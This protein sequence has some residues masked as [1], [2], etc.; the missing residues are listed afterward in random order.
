MEISVTALNDRSSVCSAVQEARTEI[1][2]I[3]LL[4]RY[5]SLSAVWSARPAMRV[6][7][8]WFA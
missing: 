3:W 6:M 2:A 1:S 7:E 8:H 5:S 4:A